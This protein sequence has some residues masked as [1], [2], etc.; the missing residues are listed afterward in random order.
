M[1]TVRVMLKSRLLIM[2]ANN[3]MV[4]NRGQSIFEFLIFLPI[5]VS[6]YVF[7][8]AIGGSIN[9]GINQQKAARG[10]FFA[11][12]KHNSNLPVPNVDNTAEPDGA[13]WSRFGMQFIGWRERWADGTESPLASCYRLMLPLGRNENDECLSWEATTTQF[14]RPAVVFGVCG[15]TYERN[16]GTIEQSTRVSDVSACHIQ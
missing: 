15:A 7:L 11:R 8:V 9:G 4:S 12:I 1:E 5:I 2:G 14:I 13:G 3:K 16:N 6:L 10:Y